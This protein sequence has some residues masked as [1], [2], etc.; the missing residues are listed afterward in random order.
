MDQKQDTQI[1]ER[2]SIYFAY[3]PKPD[4]D[5]VHGLKDV[6]QTFMIL[7]P[8]QGRRRYR[9]IVMG[10][11]EL[12]EP[13]PGDTR[14]YWGFVFKV[15]SNPRAIVKE[16]EQKTS[17]SKSSNEREWPAARPAGE[18]VYALA[19]CGDQV[20]LAYELELPE[21]PGEVQHDLHIQAAGSFICNVRNPEKGTPSGPGMPT[22]LRARYSPEVQA[23]FNDRA[24][25]GARS[26]FLD[27]E[28]CEFI[29][30]PGISNPESELGIQLNPRHET[31]ETAE[32]FTDL[33]L[34]RERQPVEP[35]LTGQWR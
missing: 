7:E 18:G 13:I 34:V 26:E 29:L 23:R 22:E 19:R 8:Q 21:H 12:P 31:E 24:Q 25:V 5:E 32:I 4:K 6:Y 33:H 15:A 1:L 3:R 28:G 9:L 27:V 10:H 30:L 2:G 16:L 35:L 20:H 17:K 11:K 14:K